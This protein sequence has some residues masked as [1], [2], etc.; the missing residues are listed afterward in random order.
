MITL[1][2]ARVW[3]EMIQGSEAWLAA[4][5][6]RATASQFKK[7]L[8][9]TGKLSAQ[10]KSYALKLAREC[11]C[12]DPFEFTGNKATDWGNEQEP[13]ARQAFMDY[14]GLEVVEIGFATHKT[15]TCVGCSPDGLIIDG[16]EVIAGLEIKCPSPDTFVEWVMADVVPAEHLPQI[17]GSMIV[18]GL[19]RWDF[20][21]YFPGAVF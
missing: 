20:V 14:T 8:T 4:R 2:T 11:V 19:K 13:H 1:P 10:S 9:P 5:K 3:P 7:I 15:M 16:G 21:A 6:G 12:D 17:H 18:T